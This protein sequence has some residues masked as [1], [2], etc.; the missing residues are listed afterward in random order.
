MHLAPR[1]HDCTTRGRCDVETCPPTHTHT[2][3]ERRHGLRDAK[4]PAQGHTAG[5]RP[6]SE[7]GQPGLPPPC[8]V[9][10]SARSQRAGGRPALH[11]AKGRGHWSVQPGDRKET[12]TQAATVSTHQLT[13][14]PF[15]ENTCSESQGGN[16]SAPKSFIG[17][18][19]EAR[20]SVSDQNLR[21][22]H[23]SGRCFPAR[24]L[25]P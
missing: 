1:P 22:D 4:W 7:Q 9:V 10:P 11:V 24:W 8:H 25:S 12:R 18:R 17:G 6:R 2:R 23:R 5:K 16:F 20:E 19:T 14:S 13:A 21:L 15:R 3:A